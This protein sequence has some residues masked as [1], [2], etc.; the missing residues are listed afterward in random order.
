M[1][2]KV[3]NYILPKYY[4]LF[5]SILI[6]TVLIWV[7]KNNHFLVQNMVNK[8]K[9]ILVIVS[10]R[11]KSSHYHLTPV[12]TL[13]IWIQK[14]PSWCTIILLWLKIRSGDTTV[15]KK[16]CLTREKCRHIVQTS[17]DIP[18]TRG[19]RQNKQKGTSIYWGRTK[20]LLINKMIMELRAGWER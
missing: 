1:Y 9:E 6:K 20:E 8:F 13:A 17:V 4:K 11:K 19:Q 10:Y 15:T 5:S 18:K 3:V 14:I 2:F 7:F 12:N 16:K